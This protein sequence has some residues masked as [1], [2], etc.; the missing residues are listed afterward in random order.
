MAQSSNPLPPQSHN[1]SQSS[2]ISP[3]ITLKD[4]EYDEYLCY[5][6]TKLASVAQTGNASACLTHSSTLDAYIFNSGASDNISSNKALFPSLVITSSLPTVTLV[7]GSQTIAK[8][9]GL[10]TSALFPTSHLC[11]LH[12]QISF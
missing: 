11:S 12:L 6:T 1:Q 2:S 9:V 7:N 10:T 4:N 8:G 5:Q 3:S